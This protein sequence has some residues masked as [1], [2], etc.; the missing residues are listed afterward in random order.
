MSE[1]DYDQ[2]LTN[3]LPPG[4]AWSRVY[5]SPG[6]AVLTSGANALE[7]VDN[8][9]MALIDEADPR[10]AAATFE[11]WLRVYGIP[12]DC[13]QGID[14]TEEQLRQALLIKVRRMGLTKEFY[15]LLSQIFGID[16]T[17]GVTNPFR[18][19]FRVDQRLY[20]TDFAHAFVIIVNVRVSELKNFFRVNFRVDNR[21]A[22]WGIEFFECL[23]R[24]NIPAHAEVIF[25]Y[26]M[27]E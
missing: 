12:S 25:R 24:E 13:M 7:A 9:A 10:T 5:G 3:L 8:T 4:P 6:S 14:V 17:V 19:N 23:I 15:R 2:G 26:E 11:D 22:T 27:G 21:L 20:G 16:I 1:R 18:V